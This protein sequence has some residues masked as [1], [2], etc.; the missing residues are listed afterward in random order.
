MF[1]LSGCLVLFLWNPP[2]V[3][4]S[5]RTVLGTVAFPLQNIL[6][7]LGYHTERVGSFFLSVGDLKREN[8]RLL[9]ENINL[10]ADVAALSDVSR[11]N[12]TLREERG[13]VPYAQFELKAAEVMGRDDASSG[14]AILLNVGETAGIRKGMA[15]VVGKKTLIGRVVETTPFASRVLLLSDS[16]SAV[17]AIAGATEARGVARGEYG[18]G[19][20]LDMVL[21]SETLREGDEVITSGLGGEVP[22]G[23]L[24]GTITKV[25]SSADRLFQYAT[26]VSPVRFDQVRFVSVIVRTKP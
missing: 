14:G 24:I 2:F 12:A 5:L 9:E 1:I 19:L 13:L 18:L 23:L 26:L 22:R 11:E 6:S 21:Q 8:E 20:A 10:K 16:A 7:F 15:V 25:E 4:F 17:N 3:A